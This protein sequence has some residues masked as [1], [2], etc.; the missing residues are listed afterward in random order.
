MMLTW[1]YATARDIDAFY[2]GRPRETLRAIVIRMDG[3]PVGLIGLAKEPDR[4]RAFSEAKPVLEPH[5]K[6]MTVLRAIKHF[7]KWVHA[8]PVPIYAMRER[9]NCLLE[10]LGFRQFADSAEVYVWPI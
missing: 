1:D 6:S 3:E 5:M 2:E 10:R 4:D 7:M 9:N 8:S